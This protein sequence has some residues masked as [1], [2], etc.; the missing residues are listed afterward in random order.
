MITRD[1]NAV[2][3]QVQR[4]SLPD[5]I[6]S[7]W[8]N[9]RWPHLCLM[10]GLGTP[11]KGAGQLSERSPWQQR[12]RQLC[13][14]II[15]RNVSNWEENPGILFLAQQGAGLWRAIV[16]NR[17]WQP[18]MLILTSIVW[19]STFLQGYNN[20]NNNNTTNNNCHFL[21]FFGEFGQKAS[22]PGPEHGRFLPRCWSPASR[23]WHEQRFGIDKECNKQKCD[24]A[25]LFP[26]SFHAMQSIET[27]VE[28]DRV[29][30]FRHCPR[31]P[32]SSASAEHRLRSDSSA[33]YETWCPSASICFEPVAK[34]GQISFAREFERA[35]ETASC[36]SNVHLFGFQRSSV[37]EQT[38]QSVYS[39]ST[40]GQHRRDSFVRVA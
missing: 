6:F 23:T 32:A 20:N 11:C 10:F 17:Q 19:L 13:T 27:S 36:P 5:S 40:Q 22:R 1:Q 9:I 14:K 34:R 21:P 24:D 3:P 4:F 18:T 7:K 26:N 25:G 31:C 37:D 38:S 12:C 30:A 28:D 29:A 39:Q 8:F 15:K 2:T 35:S 16:K 33:T